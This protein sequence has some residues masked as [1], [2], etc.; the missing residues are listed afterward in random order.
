MWAMRTT[1]ESLF[2]TKNAPTLDPFMMIMN[3]TSIRSEDVIIEISLLHRYFQ[4]HRKIA[5]WYGRHCI[6][7]Q[8]HVRG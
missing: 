7:L 3:Q 5:H 8:I 2:L 1:S 4:F 6:H